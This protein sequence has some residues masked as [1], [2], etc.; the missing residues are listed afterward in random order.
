MLLVDEER[1]TIS[2]PD[3]SKVFMKEIWPFGITYYY[4][5]GSETDKNNYCNTISSYSKNRVKCSN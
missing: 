4:L 3:K 2:Y 1:I 5:E